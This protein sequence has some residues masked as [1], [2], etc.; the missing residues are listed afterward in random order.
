MRTG[1]I[2]DF[3]GVIVDS[4]P[5]HA[6]A[7]RLVL[8]R[9]AIPFPESL[10]DVWKGRTDV[11]F[12]DHVAR[13]LAPGADPAIL[14]E[15]KRHAYREVFDMVTLIDG[16]EAFLAS[17]RP[18]FRRLGVA[19]SATV[20]DVAL[21]VDRFGL[22]PWFDTIVTSADTARHKPDPE[23]YLVALARLGLRA[24]D[25]LAIEDSPNGIRS[26]RA[27]GLAVVGLAGAFDAETLH[28]AGA[29]R[30]VARLGELEPGPEALLPE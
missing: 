9:H 4:E 24:G 7:K 5:A 17:A 6:A 23:P 21:V 11:D 18:V 29:A 2:L 15:A 22:A 19:T 25:A 1:L 8:E 28:V 16:I 12:F 27:A 10:F 30:V 13:E 20:E 26:A 3:D 14:L